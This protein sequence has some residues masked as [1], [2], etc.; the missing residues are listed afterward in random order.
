MNWDN[1]NTHKRIFY[2]TARVSKKQVIW[3]K[4]FNCFNQEGGSLVLFK[5]RGGNTLP[6]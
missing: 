3:G 6:M 1:E 5:N 4:L 2:G